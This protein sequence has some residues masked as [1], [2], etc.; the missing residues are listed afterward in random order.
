MDLAVADL[1]ASRV[2]VFIANGSASFA[3]P[4]DYTVGSQ[5]RGIVAADIDGDG[6][7]DLAVGSAAS[8][9]LSLLIGNG[10]GTF[11]SAT[12]RGTLGTPVG[13]AAGDFNGDGGLDLVSANETSAN[14]GVLLNT[15]SCPYVQYV[16]PGAGSIAGN[17]II[18]I[19]GARLS[20]ATSVTVDGINAPFN[21][22]PQP[23]HVGART[24]AHA[25][26]DVHVIVTSLTGKTDV[27]C[28]FRYLDV[29]APPSN[30]VPDLEVNG[31][32]VRISWNPV[33][34][35]TEYQI[36]RKSATEDYHQIGTATNAEYLDSTQADH[37]Y[38]YRVRAVSPGGVSA[39]SAP[40]LV[41]TVVYEND[42]SGVSDLIKARD[43]EQLRI[44]ANAL[45]ALA[46]IGD[47]TFTD[48]AIAGVRVKAIHIEQL[49]TAVTEA[50]T[51]LSLTTQPFEDPWL[52]DGPI[53]AFHH[54]QLRAACGTPFLN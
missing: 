5:P 50:R 49:R 48:A 11:I 39:N 25:A 14:V 22:A 20:G 1:G 16:F 13:L 47:A 32:Q 18:N 38:L 54:L 29:P 2:R 10:N 8:T 27:S 7:L 9:S 19:N 6:Y 51:Q 53:R 41:S 15:G 30:V 45:R 42:L 46:G 26:G 24:P 21:G 35:V 28:G 4:A 36:D 43:L 17:E 40:L 23:D 3:L 44:A 33:P 52:P 37:A 12:T 34:D 31:T